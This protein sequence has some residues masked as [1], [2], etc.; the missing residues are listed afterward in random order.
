[1]CL[2]T[3]F[4]KG[5]ILKSIIYYI[6]FSFYSFYFIFIIFYFYFIRFIL[7]Y[8]TVT[9]F[10][11]IFTFQAMLDA[12]CDKPVVQNNAGNFQVMQH[13][14]AV[15][16]NSFLIPTILDSWKDWRCSQ[17]ENDVLRI[18]F[19]T[20]NTLLRDDHPFREFNVSRLNGVHMVD[21]L[22]TF[23]KVVLII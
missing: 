8:I 5:K 10:K 12:C 17:Q 2:R 11:L 3:S 6:T 22:L 23:C 20:L 14:D 19:L 1:M 4:H 21:N 13:S 16:V 18:F 9:C 15:I 7:Y